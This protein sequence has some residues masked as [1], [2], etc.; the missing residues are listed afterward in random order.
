MDEAIKSLFL[1]H[2]MN[3]SVVSLAQTLEG[4]YKSVVVTYQSFITVTK[5]K[6]H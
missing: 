1:L 6:C 3:A 2:G 4:L 5:I